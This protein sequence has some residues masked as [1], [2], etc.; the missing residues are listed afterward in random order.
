MANLWHCKRQDKQVGPFSDQQLKQLATTGK[1]HPSDLVQREGTAQWVAAG[2]I[3][4]L[5]PVA[6][7]KP[8]G[9]VTSSL[10]IPPPLPP[11]ND[12]DLPSPLADRWFCSRNGQQS[13]PFTSQ[14]LKQLADS[15]Q[16]Q[17]DDSVWKQ[18]MAEWVKASQ[19]EGLLPPTPKHEPVS[20]PLPVVT[21]FEMPTPLPKAREV[22]LDI[23]SWTSPVP[24]PTARN[25][26]STP[27]A[28]GMGTQ[29]SSL[30]PPP[31]APALWNPFAARA[32]TVLFSPIFGAFL[33]AQNW[34]ALGE[35]GRAKRS[36]IWVYAFIG[37]VPKQAKAEG[38]C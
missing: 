21:P 10:D 24:I 38:L 35:S 31:A 34:K 15:W 36:M 29:F 8:L 11:A 20:E 14:Q 33:H 3:K 12:S 7:A 1:L 32:W 17:H 9:T 28:A 19:M 13:G 23:D 37:L 16:L 26:P 30:V 2:R 5:F 18:G 6:I 27:T 25:A 22:E 4:G